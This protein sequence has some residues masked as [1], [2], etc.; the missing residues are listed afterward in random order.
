MATPNK[1]EYW[2]EKLLKEKAITLKVPVSEFG[3]TKWAEK[4]FTY[5]PWDEL[6]KEEKDGNTK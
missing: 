1:K 4:S 5:V 3:I 6:M 2:W